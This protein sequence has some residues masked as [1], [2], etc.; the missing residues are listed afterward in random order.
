MSSNATPQ[1]TL[2]QRRG[3]RGAGSQTDCSHT[4]SDRS[5]IR[6][7]RNGPRVVTVARHRVLT[8]WGLWSAGTGGGGASQRVATKKSG[9]G[10]DGR[11]AFIEVRLAHTGLLDRATSTCT[12]LRGHIWGPPQARTFG[13]APR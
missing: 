2:T 10:V 12:I 1:G 4:S 5:V 13:E 7:F 8:N 9:F 11:S 3:T 6:I